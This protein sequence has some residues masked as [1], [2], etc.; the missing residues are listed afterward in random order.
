MKYVMIKIKGKELD[1]LV[2]VIFPDFLCHSDM[3]GAVRDIFAKTY[4]Q[5]TEVYSAGDI[6]MFAS[7]CSG[8]SVTLNVDAKGADSEVINAY[9]YFHGIIIETEKEEEREQEENLKG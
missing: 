5:E 4:K 9:D 7:L 6:E 2:P 1:R 3:A 8:H